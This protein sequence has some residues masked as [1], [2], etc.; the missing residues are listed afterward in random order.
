MNSAAVSSS[1][2]LVW[3]PPASG[4]S[5]ADPGKATASAMIAGPKPM[6]RARCGAS[7]APSSAPTAPAP[8]T[9]PMV[10][11]PSPSVRLMYST[12]MAGASG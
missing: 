7:T 9:N 6:A 12:T 5:R 3:P 2:A 4:T 10:A 11:G 8:N 1:A